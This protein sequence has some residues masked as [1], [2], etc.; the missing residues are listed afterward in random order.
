MKKKKYLKFYEDWMETGIMPLRTDSP[1]LGGLCGSPIGESELFQLF[2]PPVESHLGHIH[3]GY[4]GDAD[5][6][7]NVEGWNNVRYRFTPFRQTVVVFM[8]AMNGEL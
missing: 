8:A 2:T 6:D 4:S 5:Y 1:A 3:W 7:G